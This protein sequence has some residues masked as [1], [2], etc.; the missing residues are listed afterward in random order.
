MHDVDH[1]KAGSGN[2]NRAREKSLALLV[3]SATE[4]TAA[5]AR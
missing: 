1:S 2:E 4:I 5:S 3:V